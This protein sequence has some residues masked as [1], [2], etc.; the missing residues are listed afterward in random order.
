MRIGIVTGEYPPM[1]G[2]VGAY[3]AILAQALANAGHRVRICTR[4]AANSP[5]ADDSNIQIDSII[6]RWDW[7]ALYQVRTWVQAQQLGVVNIQFQTAAF[8]MS[9]WIHFLPAVLRP[10][11]VVTTFHDLRVPYLFP[12]AGKLRDWIVRQ[13]A[14]RSTGVIVTNHEDEQRLSDLPYRVLIPIG[15]NILKD[16]SGSF[17]KSRWRQ[18]A[19]ASEQ[20]FLIGYFGLAN[21]TKGLDTLITALS[22]LR[23][24]GILAKLVMIGS[25]AG[26]SDPTNRMFA[27]QLNAHIDQSGMRPFI[28]QTGFVDEHEVGAYLTAAD[29]V[30]LPFRDGASFRRGSLMAPIHYGCAI[31]TTTPAIA[32]P[33]FQD[34]QNMLLVRVDDVSELTEGLRQVYE[35]PALRVQLKRGALALKPLFDW[36]Q[37][38]QQTLDLFKQVV[39]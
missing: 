9:P 27:D 38:A 3:T 20:D 6:T 33:E 26:S 36:E 5:L 35:S 18:Q 31:V 23:S 13:L 2:G 15:S 16:L 17:N 8:D 10:T 28:H 14:K 34:R 1:Q 25:V 29:V 4:T 39:Q 37:I 11:P 12:K 30:A 7:R 24:Q 21:H 32:V 22:N 19:G